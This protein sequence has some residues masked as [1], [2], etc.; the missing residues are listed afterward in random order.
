M[1]LPKR[2]HYVPEVILKRF[3]DEDGWLHL[4]SRRDRR[5]RRTR[6]GNAFCEGHLYSKTHE[7]GRK[8]PTVELELSWLE[9]VI[10]PILAKFEQAAITGKPPG[11][12]AAELLAWR[13]F[14]VVQWR[15]VPDLHKTVSTDEE[16]AAQLHAILDEMQIRFPD[17]IAEIDTVR[18]AGAIRRTVRNARISGVPEVSDRVMDAM[19][20]RGVA[21]LSIT[22]PRKG[23]IVGSRPVVQ[24]AFRDGLN[25]MDE[26]TEMWLPI[27]SRVAV[28][29]GKRTELE[30]M[31]FLA[32]HSAIRR[33]NVA[34]AQQST[35]FASR[36]IEL[37]NSIARA[38]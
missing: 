37:T 29:M 9:G 30:T 3:T 34:I 14:F 4:Y 17:R 35:E 6:I 36:S 38:V 7:D 1:P 33:L 32:D 15:R 31:Y 11:L 8:D 2:H 10:G 23:L 20:S 13:F 25:L 18:E 24:M 21:V 5:T 27:S 28:G 19:A 16:S 26:A 12:T 22:A